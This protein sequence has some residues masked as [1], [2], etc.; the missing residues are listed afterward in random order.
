MA[1]IRL[2]NETGTTGVPLSG[3][4][5]ADRYLAELQGAT[6]ISLMASILRKEPAAFTMQSAMLNA[7]RRSTWSAIPVSDKEAD[8]EVA[9]ILSSMLDDMSTSWWESIQFALSCL[10]FGFS[11]LHVVYK[12]RMGRQ[13]GGNLPASQYDD[14]HIGLRKLAIRRQETIDHW[15]RD[16]NGSPKFMVQRDP[17]TG[18]EYP[19][20]PI[21]RMLHFRGGDDRGS[22]EGLGWLEPAYKLANYIFN[23]E[24]L[25]GVGLQRSFV[26]LPT[27][28][29][30][31]KPGSEDE[32][33]MK[34]MLRNLVMNQQQFVEYPAGLGKFEL[35]TVSNGNAGPIMDIIDKYR[36]LI[37]SLTL[38]QFIRLGDSG[39]GSRALA[40]PLINLFLDS[41]DGALDDIASI[42]NR[43]L[44]PRLMLAN[45]TL[46][47]RV[48]EYPMFSH[49]SVRGAPPPEST[50]QFLSNIQDFL[51]RATEED[52]L[53]I[54]ALLGMPETVVEVQEQTENVP[55][56]EPQPA[57]EQPADQNVDDETVEQ[58]IEFEPP[59]V[60]DMPIAPFTLPEVALGYVVA[61]EFGKASATMER[62][63]GNGN[64]N[65]N[66]DGDA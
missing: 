53:W 23:L 40:D 24:V 65:H 16:K 11:D 47:S 19:P 38:A 5:I 61:K 60:D 20:V 32:T 62:L 27:F 44:M 39:S 3:N 64:G 41:I 34:T 46:A 7:A 66:G 54:R 56:G 29:W 28:G 6:G 25:Q 9:D 17:D 57:D 10:P 12:R 8:K 43:H 55:D 51:D 4:E 37:F 45:P 31:T 48:E 42:L 58:E 14:K 33:A 49:T 30:T 18:K 35:M 22:W 59:G 2:P 63:Y 50:L 52:Q 21:E 36:W 13:P 26:G 15:K 1:T